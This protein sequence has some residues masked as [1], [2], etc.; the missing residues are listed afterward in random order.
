M[1]AVVRFGILGPVEAWLGDEPVALGGPRQLALLGF[2]VLHANRA[3]SSDAVIEGVWGTVDG[4]AGKRLSVA[5]ARLRRALEPFESDG[6]SR[7]RTVGGGYMLSLCAGELDAERFEALVMEGLGALEVGEPAVAG[8]RLQAALALWRGPALADVRF[9]DFAQSEIER[10]EEL[11]LVALEARID[12]DLRLGAAA[13]LVGELR[14]LLARY[15]TREQLACLLM[16]ALYRSGR[17][18]E[19]LDVYQRTRAHLASELGLEPGPQLRGLQ[20]RIL[21][22]SL[23]IDGAHSRA[24]W[25][26]RE[27]LIGEESVTMTIAQ[28]DCPASLIDALG[29]VYRDVLRALDDLLRDVWAAHAALE[30]APRERGSLA[31]FAS[32]VAA[33]DAAL[34]ACDACG[35][36]AWPAGAEV[37]VRVGV[38]TGRLRISSGGFWGEDVQYAARLADAAHGGQVLVSAVTAALAPDASVVDLGEHRLEDF[39]V[40]RRLFGLGAGP[41]RVP[42]T[43]DP[44][45][46]NLPAADG[47]LIGREGERD[48]LMAALGDR[49]RRLIT[50]TGPGGAGKTCLALAVAGAIVDV[51][52]DGAFLVALA[53]VGEAAAVAAA[54]AAPLGIHL[55]GD[56]EHGDAIGLA[57]SDRELLLVLDNFEHVL[58]AAPLLTD[59]LARAPG[60]RVIVTSQA[61]L[62]LR[63]EQVIRLEPLE[64]PRADDLASVAA[65]AASRLLI[66]RAQQAD[67]RFELTTGNAR[68]LARLCRALGGLPLGIELAAARLTLLS[69]D[70]MLA[71]L[72]DGI[73]AVG[74]GS[75]DLPARQRGLGAAL[76]WTHGL[77]SEDQARL[78]RQLGTFAGPVCLDRIERV[79]DGGP[80]LLEALAQLVDLSLVTRAGDGRFVLHATVQRY[81]RDKLAR[82]GESAEL[83]CRHGEAFADV[84]EA[85]G[86]RILFDV[87]AVESEVLAEESDIGL[88]L[89]WAAAADENC[90]ARLAGGAAMALLFTGRLSPWSSLIERALASDRAG[91]RARTWLLLGASLAAFQ[92][93]D[94]Q[95]ARVRLKSTISAAEQAADPWLACLM[96]ACSIIF[97]VLSGARNGL[98]DEHSLL[99]E[100]ATELRDPELIALIDGFEPYILGYCEARHAQAGALWTALAQDRT[101]T[102]F[103]GWTA[104]FCWPD[105]R[106]LEGDCAAA[107]D[108]F[109]AALR[110]ARERA[111][112]PTVA[113]QLEGITMSLSGLGRHHE[114]LEA[115]G[116]ADSVRQTAGPAVNSWYKQLLDEALSTSRAALGARQAHAAYARGRAL[117]LDAAVNAALASEELAAEN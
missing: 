64:L 108:G 69:A 31:V 88:A 67:P 42:R 33:L 21:E 17:Q 4:G 63:G 1:G 19:A 61:P 112:S 36:V 44:L 24:P 66:Q 70:Q 22:Q 56:G 91:G 102:D 40:P 48:Q 75:R 117:T 54:I 85:W 39:A 11:R 51:L 3:V 45:R 95:L 26:A 14:S 79:C 90:F 20:A 107:L 81:A 13:G 46:S 23:T 10:L 93:E 92:R 83:A 77:L 50:I 97:H 2:L 106:L 109:R 86:N 18:A 87:G 8:E 15:P 99:T 78:L 113:Y 5:I 104:P 115:A 55:H 52:A 111:Q 68:T 105:S 100:R 76:D 38:H 7:L 71:R 27:R 25:P 41:H 98:R 30:V 35:R 12:A 101:R 34:E 6:V 74:R 59:L 110:S 103:A 96:R 94:V 16:L 73:E 57:L 84:G 60:V 49:E 114:A 82:A 72:E 89:T 43:G 32:P 58:D 53:Q 28:I 37:R 29:G 47:E 80:D 65:A 116:W 9:E 62:R